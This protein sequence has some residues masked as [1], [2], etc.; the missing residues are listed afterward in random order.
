MPILTCR[1]MVIKGALKFVVVVFSPLIISIYVTAGW[2]SVIYLLSPELRFPSSFVCQ[3]T[4]LLTKHF[5][6]YNS[7][8][9][10]LIL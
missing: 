5:D 3:V 1:S 2:V 6:D 9:L 10:V 4:Q 7:P 8:G